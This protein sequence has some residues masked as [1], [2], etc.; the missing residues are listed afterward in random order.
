ML[1]SFMR[2]RTYFAAVS[3]FAGLPGHLVTKEKLSIKVRN[4]DCVHVDNLHMFKARKSQV[5]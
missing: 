2:L 4:V 1:G 5:L 3:D